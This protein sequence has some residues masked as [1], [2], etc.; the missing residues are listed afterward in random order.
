MLAVSLRGLQVA[1]YKVAKT[2]TEQVVREPLHEGKLDGWVN[3]L[4]DRMT[5]Q[6]T[7]VCIEI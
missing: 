3:M 5:I 4:V 6:D 7:Q 1:C 2:L